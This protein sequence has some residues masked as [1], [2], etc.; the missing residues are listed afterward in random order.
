VSYLIDLIGKNQ[1]QN[2]GNFLYVVRQRLFGLARWFLTMSCIVISH[3]TF[4]AST[5]I[6]GLNRNRGNEPLVNT[7]HGTFFIGLDT[8]NL[9]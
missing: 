2:F 6:L 3:D 4:R 8:H 7:T 5:Y 1:A 9:L